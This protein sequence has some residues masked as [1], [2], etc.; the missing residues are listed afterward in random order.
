MRVSVRGGVFSLAAPGKE[1]CENNN[2]PP[3]GAG[4]SEGWR[5]K[6]LSQR[7]CVKWTFHGDRSDSATLMLKTT[8]KLLS[9][10]I[11]VWTCLGDGVDLK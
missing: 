7:C 1:M 8:S 2:W 9:R 3:D 4:R 6:W 11:P 5:S 10:A